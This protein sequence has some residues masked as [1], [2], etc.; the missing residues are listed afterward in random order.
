MENTERKVEKL[1]GIELFE[2]EAWDKVDEGEFQFYKVKFMFDSMKQFDGMC[3][4]R[5]MEGHLTIWDDEGTETAWEDFIVNIPEFRDL[6]VK[7][8]GKL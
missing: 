6:I 8:L 4:V 5:D 2:W 1:F 3:V 7:N